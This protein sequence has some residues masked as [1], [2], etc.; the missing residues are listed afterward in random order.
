PNGPLPND[1]ASAHTN[2]LWSPGSTKIEQIE[3]CSRMNDQI[4]LPELKKRYKK[5]RLMVSR[6][7][8]P[9]R[10]H[11]CDFVKF[12]KVSVDRVF[13]SC[14]GLPEDGVFANEYEYDPKPP[15][16][17]IPLIELDVFAACLESCDDG[18]K[19]SALGPWLHD[20]FQLPPDTERTTCIPKKRREFDM[21]STHDA[22]NLVWGIQPSYA[23]S[24]FMISIYALVPLLSAFGFWIYWLARHPGDWQNASVPMVTAVTL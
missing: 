23:L 18:C 16:G 14:G 19:W 20:C 5:H 9:F 6:W 22:E 1:T 11:H 2:H 15:L 7:F 3:I 13:F 21:K 4:F 10:F 17:K 8:S 12:R 24:L